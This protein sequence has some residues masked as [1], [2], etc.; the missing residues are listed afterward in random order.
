[1]AAPVPL[2]DAFGRDPAGFD[3]V[4]ASGA[5]L[6]QRYLLDNQVRNGRP[7]VEVFAPLRTTADGTVLVALGWLPY[8]DARRTAPVPAPL[9]SGEVTVTGM[10]SPPPAH[11]LRVGRAWAEQ[12][13]YPKLMPYFSLGEVAT[14][15]DATL[16]TRVIRA[17]EEPGSGYRR[18]WKPV[19]SMPAARHQAY[20]W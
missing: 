11:G 19:D 12:T 10:L 2:A 3:R 9:P 6:P 15:M 1:Q 16:A 5:W 20:A 17:D 18:D 13:G 7:G 4:A 14:D 8:A